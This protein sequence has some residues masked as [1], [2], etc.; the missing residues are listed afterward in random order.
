LQILNENTQ[1]IIVTK[2]AFYFSA[3]DD[4]NSLWSHE[5][6]IYFFIKMFT[7]T[8]NGHYKCPLFDSQKNFWGVFLSFFE[9]LHFSLIDIICF[10][11]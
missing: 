2:Y 7:G 4:K 3:P 6:L 10:R 9:G 1:K 11:T 5:N 8:E